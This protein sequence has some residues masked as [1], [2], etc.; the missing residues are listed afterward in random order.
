MHKII[1]ALNHVPVS[2]ASSN[3]YHK[4]RRRLES[5]AKCI[6]G[7]LEGAEI[8]QVLDDENMSESVLYLEFRTGR[9]APNPLLES[10]LELGRIDS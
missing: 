9:G 2:S 8:P 3:C 7:Q 4:K 6:P 1:A 5:W 10:N